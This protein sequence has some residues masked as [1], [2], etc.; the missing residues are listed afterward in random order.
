[1]STLDCI[2]INPYVHLV[3]RGCLNAGAFEWRLSAAQCLQG[4]TLSDASLANAWMSSFRHLQKP[5]RE[6]RNDAGDDEN[7]T[8]SDDEIDVTASVGEHHQ[9]E[10]HQDAANGY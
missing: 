1:M 10:R 7:G 5:K 9:S 6:H 8:G 2:L 3:P 4:V